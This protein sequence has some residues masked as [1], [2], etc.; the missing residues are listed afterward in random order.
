MAKA[1]SQAE[2]QEIKEHHKVNNFIAT[3]ADLEAEIRAALQLA[4]PWLPVGSIQHQTTLSVSLGRKCLTADGKKNYTSLGRADI[5]LSWKERPLAILELK[6]PSLALELEDDAQGL[7]YARLV[8]PQ[9]PL[10]VV[11][12]GTDIRLLETHTGQPWLPTERSEQ[13]FASLLKSASL[14]ATGDIK[15]AISTLM[16]SNPQIWM[17]AIRKTSEEYIAE[18]SGPWKDSLKPFVSEFL[19]PRKATGSVLRELRDG[20]KLVLIEGPPLIGKSNVLREL[21]LETSDTDEFVTLSVEGDSGSG[22]L[23]QIA[24]SL[25]QSLD[26]PLDQDEVRRWLLNLSNSEGPTLVIAIDG[27]GADRTTSTTAIVDLSSHVFGPSLRIVVAVDDT[28]ADLLV[29]NSTKRKKSAIGR[30]AVRVP[31]CQLDDDEFSKAARVLWEHR[32]GIMK[33]GEFS[34]EFRLPWVLRAVMSEIVSRPQYGDEGLSAVIPPFLGLDLLRYSRTLL[35]NLECRR[36]VHAMAKAVIEDAQDRDRPISLMLESLA[37]FVI[38]RAT[39]RRHLESTDIEKLIEQAYLRAVLHDSGSDVL[40]VRTPELLA[41]EAAYV[42]S[43]ELAE[44]AQE[45]TG[46]AAEWLS[47]AAEGLPLGD[48]VAAYAVIDTA[49]GSGGLP[50]NLIRELINT[51]PQQHSIMPGSRMAMHWPGAG[52]MDLTFREGGEIDIGAQGG[53]M[54]VKSETDEEEQVT[55]SDFHSWLILSHLAG[56]PFAVESRDGRSGRADPAILLEV[57]ASPFVLRRPDGDVVPRG[58]LVHDVPDHGSFVCHEA[59][60]VEPITM[61]MFKFLSAE[62][63]NAADW[64]RV[65]A[66]RESLPLLMR[67]NIALHQ[68]A[69]L[70]DAGK[71]EFAKRMLD[72]VIRPA[73]ADFPQQ[74]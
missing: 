40:V 47:G 69:E 1:V 27:I 18:M 65:A 54:T 45:D 63:E 29:R 3:E 30:R 8:N 7:S 28:V 51:P 22:I 33:G 46:S 35:D 57:G 48:V 24:D 4:F 15:F 62:G 16:G 43:L 64:V 55:V 42:L 52:T 68:V 74:H 20:A 31:V 58:I 70:A 9:A 50:L 10:V 14:V 2:P 44:H 66:S 37:V 56:L 38:Q 5:L 11:T 26:W 61:S 21:C 71:V 25:S 12:N 6:R 41:S 36:L 59:G 13:A 53:R 49:I 17:Q 39:L 60:I 73:F 32:A 67:T 19:I 23:Q 72:D 34:P